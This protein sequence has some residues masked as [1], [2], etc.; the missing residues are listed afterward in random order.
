M[1]R[2]KREQRTPKLVLQI[3]RAVHDATKHKR[4]P[5]W[6]AVSSLG[7]PDPIGEL[8]TAVLLASRCGWLRVAGDP[9]HSVAITGTGI[10]LVE[11][12][13]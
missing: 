5:Y 2:K 3:L 7:F 10:A 8:D 11:R 9:P 13:K 4:P 6:V 1:A 12:E